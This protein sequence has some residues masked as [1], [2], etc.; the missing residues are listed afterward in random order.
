MEWCEEVFVAYIL[1]FRHY[2]VNMKL[3]M[4]YQKSI[5]SEIAYNILW[6]PGVFY[7]FYLL[8]NC[9]T[10]TSPCL[11]SKLIKL[12]LSSISPFFPI[13]FNFSFSFSLYNTLYLHFYIIILQFY[14][15]NT[16]KHRYAWFPSL[17]PSLFLLNL[18][19]KAKIRLSKLSA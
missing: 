5:C 7:F 10:V 4:G 19:V 13:L 1:N 18:S 15:R 3:F 17:S 12:P 11:G 16:L 8:L 6:Y 14:G 2:Y 9:F